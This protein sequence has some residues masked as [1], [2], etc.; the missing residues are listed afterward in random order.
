MTEEKKKV[1]ELYNEA[2]SFYKQQK[3]DDA[4]N[5]FKAALA[6]DPTDGPSAVYLER[7]EVYKKNPPPADWDGVYVMTTK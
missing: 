5:G 7:C 2:L 3:W 4:I 6:V 1:L